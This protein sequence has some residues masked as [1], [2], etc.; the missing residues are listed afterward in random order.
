MTVLPL[1]CA[2]RHVATQPAD[3]AI[4]NC[5]LSYACYVRGEQNPYA[6]YVAD[7]LAAIDKDALDP[8][9]DRE[10]FQG[11]MEGMV[12]VLRRHGDDHSQFLPEEEADPLRTEIRQEFGGI[13]VRIGLEGDPPRPTIVG[14]A[15]PRHARP[16]GKICCRTIRSCR[17]TAS[18]PRA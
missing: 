3:P 1:A 5:G 7:G 15:G 18:P 4:G 2:I 13:G 14:A 16:H 17:S 9:P 8:V 12:E 10:L 11:A 6:R